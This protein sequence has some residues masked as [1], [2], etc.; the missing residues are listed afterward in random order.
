MLTL[1]AIITFLFLYLYKQSIIN[2]YNF[3]DGFGFIF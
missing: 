3:M 2:E 1:V